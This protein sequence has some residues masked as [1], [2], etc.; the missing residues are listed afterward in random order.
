MKHNQVMNLAS[1]EVSPSQLKIDSS[2]RS[3]AGGKFPSHR[4]AHQ[5]GPDNSSP[6]QKSSPA[7]TKGNMGEQTTSPPGA[8]GNRGEQN[9]SP[10]GAKGNRGEQNTLPPGANKTAYQQGRTKQLTRRGEQNS[11]PN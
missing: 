10:P 2:L 1:S 5:P 6:A 11:S 7:G 4:T 3:R 8:K 9:T